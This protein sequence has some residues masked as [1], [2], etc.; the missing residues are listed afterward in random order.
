M[1]DRSDVAYVVNS[2]TA[3]HF[4]VPFHF[5]MLRRYCPDLKWPIFFA[6]ETGTTPLTQ[7]LQDAYA[8]EPLYLPVN[9]NGF[10]ESRLATLEALQLRGG[11]RYVV[12]MQDDFLVEAPFDD[13]ALREL[14]AT[15]DADPTVAS[16]RCMPCP[17]P[18]T[19]RTSGWVPLTRESSRGFGFSYQATLWRLDACIAWYQRLVDVLDRAAPRGRSNTEDRLHIELRTNLGENAQGQTEFW[20][21]SEQ[22][23]WKHVAW[24][25]RGRWPN[26]VYLSP[27][28]YRPTAI[29]R[30][31]LEEWAAELAKREGV[32][33]SNTKATEAIGYRGV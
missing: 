23:G 27:I 1:V 13:K 30:G 10:F 3:Y 8:V 4:I 32:V 26:A 25:R 5:T 2:T 31:R 18:D 20:A 6:T 9:A 14:F 33:L 21:L 17:G 29:V 19:P 12:L 28:P 24:A 15:M 22:L 11:I 16:A 7:L